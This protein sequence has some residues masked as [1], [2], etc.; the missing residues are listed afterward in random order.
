MNGKQS[1]GTG[2]LPSLPIGDNVEVRDVC[3]GKSEK[4]PFKDYM[5]PL[6]N[7]DMRGLD[8]SYLKKSPADYALPKKSEH[9]GTF[10]APTTLLETASEQTLS[11]AKFSTSLMIKPSKPK[12]TFFV[13]DAIPEDEAKKWWKRPYDMI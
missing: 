6:M 11:E 9:D 4:E 13:G 12:A 5:S 7:P 8:E 1:G 2:K 3:S 10:C